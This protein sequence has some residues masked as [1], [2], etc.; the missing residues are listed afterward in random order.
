MAG[1]GPSFCQQHTSKI[2]RERELSSA[3]HSETDKSL[4]ASIPG[5]NMTYTPYLELPPFGV[6]A[7]DGNVGFHLAEPVEVQLPHEG[8]EFVVCEG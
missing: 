3:V 1:V 2:I 4:V 5:K 6:M 7:L 8:A